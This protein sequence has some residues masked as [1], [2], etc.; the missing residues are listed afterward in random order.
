MSFDWAAGRSSVGWFTARTMPD[1]EWRVLVL[2]R[3]M[4][5]WKTRS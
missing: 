3:L 2:G 4:I 1:H 5:D